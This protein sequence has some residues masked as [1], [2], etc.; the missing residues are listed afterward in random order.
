[1]DEVKDERD[2]HGAEEPRVDPRG[3]R[4]EGAVLRQGVKCVE[5]LD[6]HEHRERERGGCLLA[7]AAEVLARLRGE[8]HAAVRLA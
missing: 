2:R 8:V 3:H 6:G 1:M 4:Q 7:L 5:H